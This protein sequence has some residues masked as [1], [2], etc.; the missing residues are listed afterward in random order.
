MI[1][2]LFVFPI[3]AGKKEAYLEFINVCMTEK[4]EEYK[5]LLKRYGMNNIKMWTHNLAGKDYAMFI[6]DISDDA[7]ERL[8]SWNDSTN[9]FDQ[10]FDEKLREFYDI[11]FD[12][13]PDHPAF[14][15]KLEQ[16]D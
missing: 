2:T 7:F 4:R 10:W 8:A 12:N 14:F 16:N 13:Q 9:K 1:A 6:H 3:K 5:D 15:G 11:D